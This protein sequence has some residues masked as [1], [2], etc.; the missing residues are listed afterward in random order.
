MSTY[1][2][3]VYINNELL[4]VNAVVHKSKL[5]RQ[6]IHVGKWNETEVKESGVDYNVPQI[7]CELKQKS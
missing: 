5:L 3:K 7:S 1:R 4:H 2:Q 6:D